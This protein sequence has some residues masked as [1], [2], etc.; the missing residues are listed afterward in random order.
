M[1]FAICDELA[2][3]RI[4]ETAPNK[5]VLQPLVLWPVD[6]MYKDKKAEVYFM[7]CDFF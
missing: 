5:L 6:V 3:I 7:W 2:R 4:E 1:G